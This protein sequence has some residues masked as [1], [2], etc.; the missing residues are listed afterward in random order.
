MIVALTDG[1]LLLKPYLDT[2]EEVS[3]VHRYQHSASAIWGFIFST[4]LLF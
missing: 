1:L 4:F 2:M 3:P